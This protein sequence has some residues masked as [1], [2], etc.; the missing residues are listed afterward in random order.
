MEMTEF[1]AYQEG[2]H[3]SSQMLAEALRFRL[4]AFD[5]G[6]RPHVNR[7]ELRLV[8]EAHTIFVIQG[9]MEK[10][11]IKD[12]LEPRCLVQKTPYSVYAEV[13]RSLAPVL[14]LL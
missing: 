2:D 7:F 11:V 12:P 9:G 13:R 6:H 3:G 8:G 5:Q 1:V 10:K 14:K 4:L